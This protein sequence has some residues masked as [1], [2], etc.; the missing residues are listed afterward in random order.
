MGKSIF[1]VAGDKTVS[2][3]NLA[4]WKSDDVGVT[5]KKVGSIL[6]DPVPNADLGDGNLV[7]LANGHL[8][9]V[10]RRNHTRGD[11]QVSP[12]YGIHVAESADNGKSWRLHSMV[13]QHR[14]VR[15]SASRGYWAP[16][17]FITQTGHL[18]CY[19]DDEFTPYQMGFHGHQWV[20]MK[21]FDP[22]T[23]LWADEVT[24]S[25][26]P[27]P[28][29]LSRDGMATV[30]EP[31]SGHLV[32]ALESVSTTAPIVGD[33]RQVDSD[34]GG[35]TWSWQSGRR[36][37][38]Y[39]ANGA[40]HSFSP[41]LTQGPG[42]DIYCLFANDEDNG[43]SQPAGTPAHRLHLDIKLLVSR[44]QGASWS[45]LALLYHGTGHNYLPSA[46]LFNKHE[47]LVSWLD[48]DCGPLTATLRLPLER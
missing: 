21:T 47:L 25:R 12:E 11:F 46:A 33:I 18:Q 37:A 24:V 26:A 22:A 29:E 2:Q 28:K 15:V 43:P 1:L 20:E 44:D 14:I 39:Q 3:S 9:A 34:D 38:I 48:F 31:R 41:W 10:Y 36:P 45:Q 19:Y 23:E 8:L 35:R 5:W 16:F 30:V 42:K 13:V 17:L 32:C 7:R 6:V 27:N 40:F 4:C